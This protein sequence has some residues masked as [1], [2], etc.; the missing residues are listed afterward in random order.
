MNARPQK[1]FIYCRKST[2][3][4]DRQMLS[5]DA[6]LSELN[7]IATQNGLTI[8]HTFDESKS[9]KEPGRPIFNE[10][11]R[12]IEKGEANAILTWKLDRLARNFDD[13]GKIIGLLQRGVIQEIRAFEKSYLPSDNVLMI[14]VELGM[15]NQYVRDLSVNIQR[16]IREKL[17]RGVFCGKAPLGYFNEPRLRTIEPDPTTFPIVKRILERFATAEMSLTAVQKELAAAGIVG[18]RSKKPL[19]LS[20]IGNILHN[21]FYYGVFVHKGEMHQGVHVPMIS[22]Q[23]FNDIQKALKTVG[24]PR[25]IRVQDEF[26]F[27]NF[28]TCG[29]C[30][31]SITGERHIKK[32]GLRF[33]YYRCTHKSKKQHCEDRGFLRQDRFIDEVKRNVDLVSIPDEWKEKFLARIETWETEVSEAKQAKIAL[34]RG[35]LVALKGKIDRINTAFADGALD[36][37]EFKELKNPLLPKRV[38]LE[39]QAI[40]LEK[41]A[42]NR[43]EPLKN[44]ILEANQAE[45]WVLDNNF[46][47]MKRF[48]KNVGSNRLLSGKS[49]T[50]TFTEPAYSLAK[51]NIAVRSTTDFSTQ[52]SRWW[53]LQDS[54]LP[55]PHCK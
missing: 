48:L 42:G 7:S 36:V 20:S 3:D 40:A 34:I 17:R 21:P 6:Q 35:D 31:Y 47:E 32:S 8:V 19:P 49:L 2:E 12:R 1:F 26:L 43:L 14:A 54:N 41:S 27:L 45:K 28:A 10:M 44:W 25:K 22:K 9:A 50:V 51:T 11:L 5:I 37:A 55:P 38:E 24:K 16:G 53:T 23:T 33:H 4:E 46:K 29:S 52:S 13:G 15:A 39:Q 30:G 18:S